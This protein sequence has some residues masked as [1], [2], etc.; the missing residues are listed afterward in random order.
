MSHSQGR[1]YRPCGKLVASTLLHVGC[2]LGPRC[3]CDMAAAPDPHCTECGVSFLPLAQQNLPL[4]VV[5]RFFRNHPHLAHPRAKRPPSMIQ[6]GVL[7]AVH[8]VRMHSLSR[9][10][11]DVKLET[12]SA[13]F[14]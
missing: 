4:V 3:C 6:Y 9:E 14:S 1:S 13:T 2:L 5:P 12:L 11:V 7:I 8:H 10:A